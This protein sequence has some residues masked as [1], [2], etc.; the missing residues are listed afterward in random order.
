MAQ[1]AAS[2]REKALGNKAVAGGQYAEALSAYCRAID[3]FNADK[4]LFANRALTHLKLR[5]W[6][7][8]AED[9]TR[10]IEIATFLDE[11]AARRPP[12]PALLKAHGRAT[13]SAAL[14]R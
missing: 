5:N 12:P 7:S 4:A 9:A 10:A 11:D 1:R 8:A 3:H 6:V 14:G 2:E 13:A